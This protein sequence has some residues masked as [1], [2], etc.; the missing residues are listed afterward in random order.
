[1]LP[2]KIVLTSVNLI[3]ADCVEIS[4]EQKGE[5]DLV[6]WIQLCFRGK[7]ILETRIYLVTWNSSK[8]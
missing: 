6:P 4:R 5:Q 3:F 7:P 2:R 1:M 8:E